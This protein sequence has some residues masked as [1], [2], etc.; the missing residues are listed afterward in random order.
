VFCETRGVAVVVERYFVFFVTCAELSS[1][2]SDI[3]IM[4]IRASLY[5]PDRENLSGVWS[6]WESKLPRVCVVRKAVLSSDLLKMLIM[7][8]VSLPT[9]V[10]LAHLCVVWG[11]ACF[12]WLWVVGL[13]GSVVKELLYRMLW[14]T[15]SSCWYTSCCRL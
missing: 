7:Y 12:L 3:R 6:L 11:V 1:G 15:F 10:K 4:T 5:T 8:V 13:C 2:L 9:Y 14:I